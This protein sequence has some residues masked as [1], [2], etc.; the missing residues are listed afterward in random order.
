MTDARL[1]D[2]WLS[3]RR[4]LRLSGEAFK[5]YAVMLLFSVANRTDGH[6][7]DEDMALLPGVDPG[8]VAELD[9]VGIVEPTDDGWLLTE[10]AST[11][12]SRAELEAGEESRRLERLRKARERE[13]KAAAKAGA[14]GSDGQSKDL[15]SGTS[16]GQS[17]GRPGGQPRLGK[18][19]DR[20]GQGKDTQGQA[21]V[22]DDRCPDCS[23]P[24]T[25]APRPFVD[26]LC[27]D[28]KSERNKGAA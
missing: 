14:D 18:D 21:G 24:W 17:S 9:D 1:P 26:G 10:F 8:N 22:T 13:Q 4:F 11:Q 15:S 3:D 2:R 28:C 7:D 19:K 23:R 12:T 25:D 20:Q 6:I 5:L 16:G 27:A